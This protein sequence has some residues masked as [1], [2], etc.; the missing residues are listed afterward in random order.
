MSPGI[1]LPCV[2]T[3]IFS[4][5]ADTDNAAF[6]V[7]VASS[8]KGEEGVSASSARSIGQ[9]FPPE[10]P[11]LGKCAE[12]EVKLL[13]VPIFRLENTVQQPCDPG[14][15]RKR[16]KIA[17]IDRGIQGRGNKYMGQGAYLYRIEGS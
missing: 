13:P 5:C 2:F 12:C 17:K 14:H 16:C 15:N 4:P 8:E 9:G 11:V 7:M 6:P 1:C 3:E 10:S